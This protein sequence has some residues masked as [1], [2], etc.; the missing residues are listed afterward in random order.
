MSKADRHSRKT[1]LVP[2]PT[3]EHPLKEIAI[4]FIRDLLES[5]SYNPILVVMDWF[6][7]V[8]PYIQPKTT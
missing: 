7:N 6:T 4:Y 3:E 2:R 1:K 8:Q 5:A